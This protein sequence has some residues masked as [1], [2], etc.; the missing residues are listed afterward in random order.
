MHELFEVLGAGDEIALAIDLHNYA[1][2]ASGV[3]VAGHG[4][5]TGDARSLLGGDRNALL[6]QDDDRLLHVTF[7]FGEG[8]LAVHH[9]GAGL[10]AEF[11]DL[12]GRN[13]WPIV[14][15]G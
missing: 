10:L 14:A 9:G 11:L 7:G 4:A 12:G 8:L 1:D 13:I 3:D 2:L 5:F 6:P 15:I